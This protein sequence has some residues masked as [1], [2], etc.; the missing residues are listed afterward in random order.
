MVRCGRCGITPVIQIALF[1][2]CGL[3][4]KKKLQVAVQCGSDNF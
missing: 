1:V 3:M 2:R 4:S